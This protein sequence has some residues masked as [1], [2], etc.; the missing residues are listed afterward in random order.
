MSQKFDWKQQGL[1]RA[2][3]EALTKL[4]RLRHQGQVETPTRFDDDDDEGDDDVQLAPEADCGSIKTSPPTDLE[5]GRLRRRFLDRLVEL[6]ANEKGGRHVTATAMSVGPDNVKV[7]VARNDKFRPTD[8]EFLERVQ[9]LL[10]RIAATT[11]DGRSK[12]SLWAALLTR[13]ESRTQGYLVDV[14]QLLKRY[15]Q[16]HD[17]AH[18]RVQ[19]VAPSLDSELS[20]LCIA[21]FGQ[22]PSTAGR[23]DALVTRAHAIHKMFSSGDFE[24]LGFPASASLRAALGYLGLDSVRSRKIRPVFDL[25][26][27]GQLRYVPLGR[28]QT[29]TFPLVICWTFPLLNDCY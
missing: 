27:H 18:Q 26:L 5:G 13:S 23:D 3:F 28:D 7:T 1:D 29:V 8:R 14:R 2:R 22:H 12:D 11:Q 25:A 16:H 21:V 19:A 20:E 6:I 9:S 17:T 24:S 4:L 10:R 15:Q